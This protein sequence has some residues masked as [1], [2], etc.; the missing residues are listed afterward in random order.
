MRVIMVREKSSSHALIPL[1]SVWAMSLFE[2]ILP[3][4]VSL[5]LA[6]SLIWVLGRVS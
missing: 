3:N 1:S 5:M 4:S 2:F 6:Y